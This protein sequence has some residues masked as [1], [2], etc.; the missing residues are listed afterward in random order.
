MLE[1]QVVGWKISDKL[2]D[3]NCIKF[4]FDETDNNPNIVVKFENMVTL[5]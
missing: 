2:T 1:A 5:L 3:D 4:E